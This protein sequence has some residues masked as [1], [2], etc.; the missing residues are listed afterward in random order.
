MRASNTSTDSARNISRRAA[1]LFLV[2]EGLAVVL[3][4]DVSAAAVPAELSV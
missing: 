3:V 1:L 4:E 2:V